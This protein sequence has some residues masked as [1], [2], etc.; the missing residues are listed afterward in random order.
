MSSLEKINFVQMFLQIKD[1]KIIRMNR[2]SM[3]I[4][5]NG[6]PYLITRRLFNS[7]IQKNDRITVFVIEKEYCGVK[8]KWLALPSI[9]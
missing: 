3:T 7:I 9:F 8:S 2:A 6:Y 1:I 5:F 4:E